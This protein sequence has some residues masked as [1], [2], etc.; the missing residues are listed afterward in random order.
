MTEGKKGHPTV[1]EHGMARKQTESLGGSKTHPQS[2]P[3][4]GAKHSF[5]AVGLNSLCEHG[6]DLTICF[7]SQSFWVAITKK[8]YAGCLINKINL[9]LNV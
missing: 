4:S 5:Q 8:P 1:A 7:L 6:L 9:F 3:S 2:L